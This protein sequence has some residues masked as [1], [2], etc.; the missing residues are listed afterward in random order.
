MTLRKREFI[1][2]PIFD[3]RDF[4]D[5]IHP[6]GFDNAPDVIRHTRRDE[7]SEM[8]FREQ[9]SFNTVRKIGKHALDTMPDFDVVIGGTRMNK[10]RAKNK[11]V[12]EDR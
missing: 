5:N 6:T 1:N 11:H 7:Q 4:G 9:L 8:L 2:Q 3:D 12:A 10:T